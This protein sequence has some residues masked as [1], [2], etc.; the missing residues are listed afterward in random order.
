MSHICDWVISHV[1]VSHDAHMTQASQIYNWGILHTVIRRFWFQHTHCNTLQ[2]TATHC[3]RLQHFATR[4][5]NT[6]LNTLQRT[7]SKHNTLQRTATHS[8]HSM[9]TT[10]QHTAT[11]YADTQ[12]TVTHCNTESPYDAQH[13][14]THC[15]TLQL[16][17]TRIYHTMHT[18]LQHVALQHNT[19]QHTATRY[20]TLQHVITRSYH[21]ILTKL[22]HTAT[23]CNTQSPYDAHYPAKHWNTLQHTATHCNT[24]LQYDAHI[25]TTTAPKH[26][27][28][29]QTATRTYHTML[30]ALQRTALKHKTLHWN[31][32]HFDTLQRTAKHCNILQ[33]TVTMLTILQHTATHCNTLQHA[34]TIRCSLYC[35][36]LQHTAT[37]C[38]TLQHTATHSYHTMLT[39]GLRSIRFDSCHLLWHDSF[40]HD[41]TILRCAI[42]C[43]MTHAY[44][45]QW[46][47]VCRLLWQDSFIHDMIIH[48]WN[49]SFIRDIT[50]SYMK[51]LIHTWKNSS[52]R[53]MTHTHV[54][55]QLDARRFFVS[56]LILSWFVQSLP[57]EYEWSHSHVW[58]GQ[59]VEFLCHI[60]ARR[61]FD[62]IHCIHPYVKCIVRIWLNYSTHNIFLCRDLLRNDCV[63]THCVMTVSRLKTLHCA[64]TQHTATHCNT[65]QDTALIH[66]WNWIVRI[67]LNY[68]THDVFWCRDLMRHD[69]VMTHC[70]MTVSRVKTRL[71]AE[72]QH[73]ARRST[74]SYVKLNRSYLT[75]LFDARHLLVSWLIVSYE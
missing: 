51:Y 23:H 18:T 45:T 19:L 52:I 53:E 48:A 1:W 39:T 60:D 13:T 30:T 54:T 50:H 29:Q 28:L 34:V 12:H 5:Y 24:Q 9:L 68:L 33:H 71:C 35:N 38:N 55:Q 37:H 22:Q 75:Q 44:T 57:Y 72:T 16:T 31:T 20:N 26:L 67:W 8:H 56:W 27:T 15:N 14:A 4:R 59:F 47:D 43:D 58:H 32:T 41:K 36:T 70:V 7:T 40:I 63:M 74:Y 73:T 25:T 65:L 69:C 3:C 61:L 42:C 10:L 6:M 46:F 66:T 17:A 21:T 62:S 64:E 2:H 11:H 49:D